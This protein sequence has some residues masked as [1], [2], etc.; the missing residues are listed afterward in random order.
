[1][2]V[3]LMQDFTRKHDGRRSLEQLRYG[4]NDNIKMDLIAIKPK[5]V[6]FSIR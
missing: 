6:E 3:K 5:N 2:D 1:M 4:R